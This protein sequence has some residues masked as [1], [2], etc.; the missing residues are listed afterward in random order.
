MKVLYLV[1][2]IRPPKAS[3]SQF[4]QNLIFEASKKEV[5][6]TILS[7]IYIHTEANMSLWAEQMERKYNVKFVLINTPKFIKKRF[8]LHLAITPLVTTLA[9]L[10][11]LFKER[12][13]LVHEFTSTPA[14][15]FRSIFY[16]FFNLPSIF[17][18]S[19]FN[20]TIF[21]KLFWF[22]IF[23]FASAYL[24]PSQEI[25]TSVQEL[26]IA[27]KKLFYLPPGIKASNFNPKID[28]TQAR[29]LLGL[30]ANLTLITYY[31]PAS[32]EKGVLDIL[33]ASRLLS[34]ETQNKVLIL[35]YCYYLKEYGNF[36]DV[37]RKLKEAPPE[38]LKLYEKYVNIPLLL[39]ASDCIIYPPRTGHGATIPAISILE[40]MA[41]QKPIIATNII[42]TRELVNEG[43]GILVPPNSAHDL[44]KAIEKAAST[45]FSPKNNLDRFNLGKVANRL[46]EIYKQVQER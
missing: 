45:K 5:Q 22:K 24:L 39:S 34:K 17:T 28:K 11:L 38:N 27:K 43:N 6:A 14:I 31:G 33:E 2:G 12:F 21:G 19:V 7:P 10:K 4:I 32:E 25:E 29:K 46:L 3:G 15:A 30:P 13:D 44:T 16:K 26:G 36:R 1:T 23:D 42:G 40:T 20:K 41:S 37:L 35:L 18:L 9:V 8:L